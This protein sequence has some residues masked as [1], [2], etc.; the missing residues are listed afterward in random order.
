MKKNQL[1]RTRSFL[2]IFLSTFCIS[3][4]IGLASFFFIRLQK[5]K[6]EDPSYVIEAILQ[7]SSSQKKLSTQYL[8]ECLDLSV[9]ASQNLLQFDTKKGEMLLEKSPYI[10]RATIKKMKPNTL[11]IDYELH[12][13]EAKVYDLPGFL[14]D[15]EGFFVPN[16]FHVELPEVYL[17][18]SQLPEKGKKSI[19]SP[20]LD[21]AFEVLRS[22]KAYFPRELKVKRIDVSN[23]FDPSFGKRELVLILEEEKKLPHSLQTVFFPKY[24]RVNVKNYVR[25]LSNFLVLNESMW[26]DYEKQLSYQKIEGD[27]LYFRPK[28]FDLRIKDLAF[29]DQGE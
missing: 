11:Y 25:Q 19:S 9:E 1:S 18:L 3:L 20:K 10:K 24:L 16:I 29:V 28:I 15:K 5:S 6:R 21:Y 17:G 4:P 26:Q 27:T 7:T 23:A 14:L 22:L 2:L 8:A 13:P 12:R